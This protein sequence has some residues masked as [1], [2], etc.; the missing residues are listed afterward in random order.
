M[1]KGLTAQAVERLKPDP[2]KRLEVPD[3]LLPGLYFVIQPSGAKS[4]AVR[5]RHAAKPRKLTLGSYPALDL[6]TARDRARTALQAVALGR[7]PGAEKQEARRAARNEKPDRDL[8]PAVLETFLERHVRAKTKRRSAEEA[9]RIFR[10][11][12]V[13]AWGRRQ[14]QDITRRDVIEHLDKL[15]DAGKPVLANR[16]LAHVRKFFNWCIDRSII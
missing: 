14:A 1:A 5:Y 2:A 11:H 4:W 6:G 13:P 12:V 3:G 16:T 8:F 7:D 15:V 10:K 9:E